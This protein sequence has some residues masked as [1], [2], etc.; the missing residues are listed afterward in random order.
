MNRHQLIRDFESAQLKPKV[1]DIRV[2]ETVKVHYKIREGNKERVQIFEGLVVATKGGTTIQGSFTVRKVISS[3]GVERTFPLHS[4]HI[5]KIE[6]VKTGKVRKARLNFVRQHALSSR[7]KLKDKGV[8][9]TIWETIAEDRAEINEGASERDNQA[10]DTDAGAAPE[11]DQE[12][13]AKEAPAE[14]NAGDDVPQPV[15]AEP[16]ESSAENQ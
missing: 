9:G 15:A 1:A 14:D 7:F 13:L 10:E 5:I 4:P 16:A 8:A 12:P 6:R 3:I 2:G 11:A